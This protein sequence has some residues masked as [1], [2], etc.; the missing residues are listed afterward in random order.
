[1]KEYISG[2][3][4][5]NIPNE[6]GD[7]INQR[8][9]DFDNLMPLKSDKNEYGIFD[10]N[11][12]G[13]VTGRDSWAYNFSKEK[14]ANSMKTCIA[15]Y[16]EDLDK[17]D[18]QAFLDKN[19]NVKK[20]ELYKELSDKDITIDN[21]KIAWTRAL[22]KDLINNEKIKEFNQEN[23]RTI[24]HRPFTKEYL[25]WDKIWNEEQSQLPKLFPKNKDENLLI[26]TTKGDFS[27]LISENIPDY[28]FIG[29]TQAFP[30][31]FYQEDGS[32]EYAISDFILDKFKKQLQDETINKEEI[33]YYI[34]A[35][36]HHKSY[37]EKY[38]FEL[39]KE[40]PRVPISKD[41]KNL[42]VL[43][44]KL[45]TLHLNYENN[46]MFKKVKFKDGILAETDNDEFYKV[47]K[48]KKLGNDIIYNQN[49]T[50]ENI[51]SKAFE[52]K[53]NGKSAIDWI[54]DRY[55]ISIDKKSLIE[56]NPNDYQGGKYIYELL[57]K[58]IDLSIKSVD[59]MDEIS[60]M[61]WE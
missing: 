1:M 25:Y 12:T 37:L 53:I 7:W 50:I 59:L 43:G 47:T 34:Y 60:K 22:K 52:Y 13:I 23:I 40:A 26:N 16:N 29:D 35:I 11:A 3:E 4:A 51:P 49:I 18:H 55:Q 14:L 10:Y 45:A 21:T 6:K 8:G 33:F 27:A 30:L 54:I 38:K 17:F 32:K 39:S 36:F 46:E 42:S 56:N 19:K 20:S 24:S 48:M 41:F 44:K 5:L 61:E 57:L 9:K 15:T 28:H 31:Y 58:I 2:W